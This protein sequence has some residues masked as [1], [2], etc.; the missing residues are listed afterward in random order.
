MYKKSS[1]LLLLALFFG[2]SSGAMA[3]GLSWDTL[4]TQPYS[5]LVAKS[6]VILGTDRAYGFYTINAD[7]SNVWFCEFSDITGDTIRTICKVEHYTAFQ[8]GDIWV[9][10]DTNYIIGY[11]WKYHTRIYNVHTGQATT[12]NRGVEGYNK[13]TN[14]IL[15]GGENPE[16]SEAMTINIFNLDSNKLTARLTGLP[17]NNSE[18]I[19][20]FPPYGKLGLS[21]KGNYV[22]ALLK[23]LDYVE[24]HETY[25]FLRSYLFN[26]NDL[27]VKLKFADT[28]FPNYEEWTDSIG[29]DCFAFTDDETNLALVNY[30]G[31]IIDIYDLV[32]NEKIKR[33]HTGFGL[34][35]LHNSYFKFDSTGKYLILQMENPINQIL[36][37]NVETE[38]I[39]FMT[40]LFPFYSNRVIGT[41]DF[42]TELSLITTKIHINQEINDVYN[43]NENKCN[44]SVSSNNI[45][46]TSN[47]HAQ[48]SRYYIFNVKGALVYKNEQTELTPITENVSLS[49][50]VY[51]V[52]LVINGKNEYHKVIVQ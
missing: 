1:F 44:I 45:N 9:M 23:G 8:P 37:Y 31:T 26:T 29:F 18:F 13:T 16:N 22:I 4:W 47:E 34:G 36:F 11:D 20:D 6:N 14:S 2:F 15:H 33:I 49:T 42:V 28:Y 24:L 40:D 51:F 7:T 39:D 10:K 30:A 3:N 35:D 43:N 38:A 41:N 52:T 21:P 12:V 48:I 19:S 25:K 17:I 46:I 27:S 32:A 5:G 50:G